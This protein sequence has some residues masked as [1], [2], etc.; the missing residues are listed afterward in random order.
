VLAV[1]ALVVAVSGGLVAWRAL[2]GLAPFHPP[3]SELP[4]SI[5]ETL[6]TYGEVPD[7]ALTERSGRTVTRADLVGTVWLATFIYTQCTETC[8]LQTARVARLQTVFTGAE[9][10]RFVSITV[11]PEHDT[12]AVLARY[13][14]G[15][16]ADPVRWLFLT[17]NKRVI[18]HL[19]KDGFRLGVVDP[20]DPAASAGLG[21][22]LTPEPAWATHG[23]KGLVMHSSRFVLVDRT[24]QIRAYHLPDD[25]ASLDRLQA[26]LRTLLRETERGMTE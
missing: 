4:A 1:A 2:R 6:G 11:D 8:P 18:Y 17:G 13:A 24:A 23:S 12:P 7:F 5:L 25:E 26:N 3:G 9:D 16:G 15:Y 14:E 10:L 20:S 19:A 22:W 21:R